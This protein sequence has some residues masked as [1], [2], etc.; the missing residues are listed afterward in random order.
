M[1]HDKPTCGFCNKR[2]TRALGNGEFLC[3]DLDCWQSEIVFQTR[4]NWGD[5]DE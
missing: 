4:D 2:S 5:D 3:D 1:M